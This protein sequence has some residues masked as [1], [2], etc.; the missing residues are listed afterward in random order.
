MSGMPRG[1]TPITTA[2]LIADKCEL[3][4]RIAKLKSKAARIRSEIIDEIDLLDDPR[5]ADIL[6][7]YFLD[8]LTMEEVAARYSYTTR[9]AY[10]LYSEAVII[11]TFD[12]Q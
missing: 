10:R 12:G 7:A 3:E 9:H 4:S 5:Y 1:G 6:E 8:G 2:D 11:L